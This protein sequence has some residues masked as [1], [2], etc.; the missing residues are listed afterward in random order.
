MISVEVKAK[1]IE[2][3]VIAAAPFDVP[4]VIRTLCMA[5]AFVS[6]ISVVWSW[7]SPRERV[8]YVI[9]RSYTGDI[10]AIRQNI[11]GAHDE[12]DADRQAHGDDAQGLSAAA[13]HFS[14]PAPDLTVPTDESE[15][16]S[17]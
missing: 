14:R 17:C 15:G 1:H 10:D 2:S 12:I 4:L 9:L 11:Q 5:L 6:V 16:T 13:E 3:L 8:K 7:V